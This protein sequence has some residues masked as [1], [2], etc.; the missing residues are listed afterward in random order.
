M[1]AW[2]SDNVVRRDLASLK[3]YPR[4]ARTHSDVQ[5]KQIAGAITEFGWTTPILVSEDGTVIAGHGRIEA[6]KLLG[7][8]EAPVMVATGWSQKQIRAYVLADNQIALNSGW[9]DDILK[10]ELAALAD[11]DWDL[12]AIG[13]TDYASLQ[14][15]NFEP[16]SINDQGKLDELTPRPVCCPECGNK[17]NANDHATKA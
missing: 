6:A 12:N 15:M 17:F 9:D 3:P 4:N 10:G 7:I 8:T 11:D 5:V 13:F 16:G 14:G 2:P 1:P